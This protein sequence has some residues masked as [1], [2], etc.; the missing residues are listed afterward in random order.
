MKDLMRMR[1]AKVAVAIGLSIVGA[2]ALAW[3]AEA[4]PVATE[5]TVSESTLS[6]TS[7]P[8][9]DRDVTTEATT[10]TT[11]PS[12][13][14]ES[15]TAEEEAAEETYSNDVGTSVS[16]GTRTSAEGSE[17]T[18]DDTETTA[19]DAETAGYSGQGASETKV[20][21][22]STTEG[23][24]VE[25]TSSQ[26]AKPKR[27]ASVA[28]TTSE[29]ASAQVNIRA[30]VQDDGW[31]GWVIDG[32][33][34][35]TTGQ[36]KRLE[37]FEATVT[38]S[39]ISGGIEYQAHVQ[40]DGWQDWSSN[41]ELAGTTG[42][43][44]R[45]EAVRFRLTG[46]LADSFDVWYRVHAQTFG[47][48]AWTKNGAE[49]GTV[50]L[51]GRMEALQVVLLRKG[52]VAPSSKDQGTTISYVGI[53]EI[54]YKA[55]AR[56]IGWQGEVSDGRVSGTTGQSRRIEAIT[57]RLGDSADSVGG[58]TYRAHVQNAGWLGWVSDGATA[59]TTGQSR[60]LEAFQIKLTGEL[61]KFCDVYYEA[62]VQ[63]IGW[64]GWASNGQ[65][66]GTTGLERAVEAYRVKLVIRG[67]SAPG[68]T[69]L[70]YAD[71]SV[72]FG[73]QT[74]GNYYKV[75]I[76]RVNVGGSGIFSY[77]S[78]VRISNFATRQDCINA[79]ITRA[80]DYVGTPYK[81]DYSCAPG[82]GVDCAGLVMQALYATGMD[83]GP[84]YTP[85]RH[86]YVAGNDH[87]AND[88]AADN[89]FARVYGSPQRG[90]LVFT[91]GHV[92]IYIGGGKIV[93]A[94][95]PSTGVIVCKL[96]FTPT[97]IRRPFV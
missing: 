15:P 49:A 22:S 8:G 84:H 11:Q 68:S 92:A 35:G 45:V 51:S 75:G 93:E 13:T 47:W 40:D 56:D 89:R 21:E 72:Y 97:V 41:G 6:E 63:S 10:V 74:P 80:L 7:L 28:T 14:S 20:V 37:A 87:Y 83:L 58:V 30:H 46:D 88:M 44:K 90:D 81:W 19:N 60:R 4:V 85:Y 70:H 23:P 38:T 59:G 33:A 32:T 42:Q 50:G 48:M 62:H 9:V 43:S 16:D 65:P 86:K 17:S 29:Q 94:R 34:A 73:Y 3:G 76:K 25:G 18:G 57:V 36:S 82:V 54:E 26:T 39:G 95:N 12:V 1:S 61:S 31:Q 67:N 66:A 2:P 27:V 24:E 77:S 69:E 78:P 55:H 5:S 96:W 53:P 71:K 91:T 64:M 52:A 79:F